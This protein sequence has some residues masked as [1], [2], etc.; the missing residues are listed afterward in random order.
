MLGK[1]IDKNPLDI[2]QDEYREL[3][4]VYGVIAFRDYPLDKPALNKI[5]QHFGKLQKWR[6]QQAPLSTTDRNDRAVINIFNDGWLGKGQM[7]W[8]TDQTY[9]K[10]NYLPVRSL[11]CPVDPTPGNITSFM[12]VSTMTDIILEGYPELENE[13]GIYHIGAPDQ[14]KM[15]VERPILS[16]CD[17]LKRKVLRFD[18]RMRFSN[19]AIDVDKFRSLVERAINE[20]EKFSLEWRKNDF[21]IFDNNRCP[22]R[23]SQMAGTCHLQR[24]TARFWLTDTDE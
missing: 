11:Y 3:L 2:E 18:A 10:G 7:N 9:L 13:S 15:D 16:Y 1:I 4:T 8:H 20:S 22:H 24:L 23:R 14:S 6:E 19:P 17:H 12:D 5:I 21:I